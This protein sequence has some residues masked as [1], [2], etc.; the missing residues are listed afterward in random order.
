[1]HLLNVADAYD[2]FH[3]DSSLHALFTDWISQNKTRI[4]MKEMHR[5][6]AQA[7]APRATASEF[8]QIM[9]VKSTVIQ[10]SKAGPYMLASLRN[11]LSSRRDIPSEESVVSPS[12]PL[13]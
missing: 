8:S 2:L 12:Y 9:Q 5:L 3:P 4:H 1:M 13:A 6:S 11:V 10:R 7:E